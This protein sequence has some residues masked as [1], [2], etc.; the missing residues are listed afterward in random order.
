MRLGFLEHLQNWKKEGV[1]RSQGVVKAK[2]K[3]YLSCLIYYHDFIML[4]MKLFSETILLD[5]PLFYDI[6]NP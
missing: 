6:M 5:L 4:W 3:S 2:V 1:K